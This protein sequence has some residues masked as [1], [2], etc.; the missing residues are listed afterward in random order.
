[1]SI[2]VE[3]HGAIATI[4]LSGGIDY[5]TQDQVRNAIDTALSSDGVQEICADF[6]GVTFMDSSGIR[7][8]VVLQKKASEQGK[9][10][11]LKNCSKSIRE[12]F[13]IGGFDQM[14]T[15]V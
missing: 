10:L 12:L 2:A 1:M 9:T 11:V 13:E 7:A 14:F 6:S 5:S 15:I 4:I 3:F 8:L